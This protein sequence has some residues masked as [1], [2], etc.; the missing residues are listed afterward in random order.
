MQKVKNIVFI[1]V[2]IILLENLSYLFFTAAIP[3]WYRMLVCKDFT[4]IVTDSKSFATVKLL[5]FLAKSFKSM[6]YDRISL[7]TG[8]RSTKRDISEVWQFMEFITGLP[9]LFS[10]CVFIVDILQVSLNW[11]LDFK[12]VF[13]LSRSGYWSFCWHG[14][15]TFTQ[16]NMIS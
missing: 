10:W 16:R 8:W 3:S 12:L 9:G 11:R 15:I 2:S 5:I 6:I 13:L 14:I 4:S 1:F 7:T